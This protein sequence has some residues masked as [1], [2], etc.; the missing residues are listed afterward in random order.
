MT[1]TTVALSKLIP[2]E[3]NVR[4]FNSEAGIEALAA[5]IA[6]HG[7]IQSLNVKPTAKGKFEVLAG[8]RRLRALRHLQG[9]GGCI[10][11]QK[12]T[13]DYPV[14]V[15]Q[16]L[17][18]G[19]T[20]TEISLA[21]NFQRSAMHPVE[22]IAAFGKLNKDEGISPEEIAARFG[23]SRMTVRRRLVLADLSPR[24]LEELR[25]DHMSLE[26]AQALTITP[27]HARQEAAWFGAQHSWN[28]EPQH[29][30]R[31]LSEERLHPTDKI[32]HF[33]REE[34]LAAAGAVERDLFATQEQVYLVDKELAYSLA[35]Q[36]LETH[37][38]AV[39]AEGWKWITVTPD[40]AYQ[41]SH[42]YGRVYAEKVDLSAEDQARLDALNAELEALSAQLEEHELYGDEDPEDLTTEQAALVENYNKVN[43][44]IERIQDR[45]DVYTDEQ[46]AVAGAVVT[47]DPVGDIRIERGLIAPQDRIAHEAKAK[48]AERAMQTDGETVS[49]ETEADVDTNTLSAALT[50]DL[51]A[52]RTA[53]LAVELAIRPDVAILATTYSLA[54][55]HFYAGTY[56]SSKPISAVQIKRETPPRASDE[57]AQTPAILA[58]AALETAWRDRLPR[59][60]ADLWHWCATAEPATLIDLLAALTGLSL[61]A[62]QQRHE[63]RH[64]RHENADQIA[65]AIN[66]DMARHWQPDTAFFRRTSKAFMADAI[67]E[68]AS[69]S[70]HTVAKG[71]LKLGK[72]EAIEAAVEA[73]SGRGWLPM[74][75]RT[76]A[77]AVPPDALEQ[78]MDEAA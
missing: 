5:D 8:G 37:R 43:S 11:G 63:K 6:A 44:A 25:Q 66:F 60:A 40:F 30:K 15:L 17:A 14:P 58:L 75:L 12:V 31:R 1:I 70:H 53:A 57:M 55:Q 21:E 23:I 74:P 26:Q 68:A 64:T 18:E 27:D 10:L 16:G 59:K 47:L 77:M 39:T 56:D 38:E 41:T 20:E 3:A 69:E 67:K 32:S 7:L 76:P 45:E 78:Q 34:Y 62:T 52:Q 72:A 48:A 42:Q 22:A 4:R 71:L 49:A 29:L 2:S 54:L 9:K 33:I 19:V 36:K 65:R 13:K 28:R 51:T 61:N 35:E 46:K 73:M 24:I 50:E